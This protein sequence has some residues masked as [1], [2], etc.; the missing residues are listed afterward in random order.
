MAED[1]RRP[2]LR[3]RGRFLALAALTVLLAA[4]AL[5]LVATLDAS[6][7]EAA[8]TGPAQVSTRRPVVSTLPTLPTLGE[9]AGEG[10]LD[11]NDTLAPGK[12][13]N[14]P[15]AAT[16]QGNESFDSLEEVLAAL[17]E[18]I[19][20]SALGNESGDGNVTGSAGDAA[21]GAKED[22]TASRSGLAPLAS[23]LAVGAIGVVLAAS[24]LAAARAF[25]ARSRRRGRAPA[26]APPALRRLAAANDS[27]IHVD[28]S[29]PNAAAIDGVVA[30]YR[31]ACEAL[32][33]RGCA[34]RDHETAREYAVRAPSECG[35]DD[36]ALHELTSY[37]ELARHAGWTVDEETA[38]RARKLSEILARRAALEGVHGR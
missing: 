1:R 13:E 17:N 38:T 14:D 27:G 30:A 2:A 35:V 11:V 21:G 15:A 20:P 8:T 31:D 26:I 37:F 7:P 34:K 3:A 4:S 32:A 22:N 29:A 36:E 16:A 24:A 28:P 9:S 33:K 10:A 6:R 18:S 25:V 19:T 23:F 12:G 5:A